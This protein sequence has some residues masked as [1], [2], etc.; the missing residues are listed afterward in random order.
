MEDTAAALKRHLA[1]HGAMSTG[2]YMSWCLTGRHGAYYREGNPLG[3]HGDF[4]T[5]PEVSQIFG[6]L[7]AMWAA[8][9]WQAMGEPASLVLV[10]MGPGRGTLMQDA[11]RAAKSVPGFLDAAYVHLVESSTS[12]REA[13]EAML[14]PLCKP[15]W[16]DDISTVPDAPAIVIA[17]EFFDAMPVEQYVLSGG[18]WHRRVVTLN[19][20][21]EPVFGVGDPARPPAGLHPAA[22]PREGDILECRPLLG[23]LMAEFGRRA[24]LDPFAMLIADYGYERPDYGDT[25]QAVRNHG[26]ANPLEAPGETDLSAH[27]NFAELRFAA[28]DAGLAAWGPLSQGEFLLALGLEHRLRQLLTSAREDQRAALYLGARRL[29]D[30]YQM[31]SLFKVMALTGL[32]VPV[33]PPFDRTGP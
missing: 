7:V 10:E 15:H 31:G 28:E 33:P 25:L 22:A 11:L 17:N 21:G 24:I 20:A 30:P 29:V 23:P 6:E 4:V 19:N 27:V 32:G 16:H 8:T 2:D 13:Q 5:A 9:V 18:E 12:L 14:S 26:Y 3:A 1:E